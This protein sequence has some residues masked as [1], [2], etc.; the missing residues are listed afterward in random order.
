MEFGQLDED[1]DSGR[2]TARVR[3]LPLCTVGVLGLLVTA[4]TVATIS[5]QSAATQPGTAAA[6]I[7]WRCHSATPHADAYHAKHL[8]VGDEQWTH[9]N[10]TLCV[11]G[12]AGGASGADAESAD[13]L[14][15]PAQCEEPAVQRGRVRRAIHTLSDAE[16]QR[17]VDA[18][19]VLATVSTT[20]G[21]ARYGSAYRDYLFHSVFHAVSSNANRLTPRQV[22]VGFVDVTGG[23]PQQPGWH[24]LETLMLEDS[25][26]AVDPAIGG[27][28]YLDWRAMTPAL[29]DRYFGTRQQTELGAFSD[30][31]GLDVRQVATT[32]SSSGDDDDDASSELYYVTTGGPWA[33]FPVDTFEWHSWYAAQPDEVRALFGEVDAWWDNYTAPLALTKST[34]SLRGNFVQLSGP[35]PYLLRS[36]AAAFEATLDGVD[37]DR[38][39]AYCVSSEIGL[40]SEFV[41]CLEARLATQRDTAEAPNADWVDLHALL[42]VAV[43][44]DMGPGAEE[45]IFWFH[46]A[47]VDMMRRTWQH[48]NEEL[49][50]W[51]YG[52]PAISG[53]SFTAT[54]LRTCLGCASYGLGFDAASLEQL[55]RRTGTAS[56]VDVL[57]GDVDRLYTYDTLLSFDGEEAGGGGGILARDLLLLGVGVVIGALLGRYRRAR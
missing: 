32:S 45:P 53:Y 25:L 44:G 36:G 15:C 21:I 35:F 18:F 3:M 8:I 1:G 24:A 52:Y 6:D 40:Y 54:H 30:A 57:C 10:N 42:H 48:N 28:P 34:Q 55:G 20:E 7:N 4:V 50:P 5:T 14:A 22:E 38:M 37:F 56:M 29:Y 16:W 17:V 43:G 26:L 2:P 49:R 23:G 11:R 13:E 51:A 31:H 47:M 12:G 41:A 27:M 9:G 39:V 46:H 19:W 33:L